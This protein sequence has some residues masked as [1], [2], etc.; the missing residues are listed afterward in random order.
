MIKPQWLE[1]P[2]SRIKF[3]GTKDVRAI[4]V[5]LYTGMLS[6]FI[7]SPRSRWILMSTHNVQFNDKTK[8]KNILVLAEEYLRY[9]KTSSN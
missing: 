6:V 2:M 8:K 3:N 7:R 5:L 1:L 9:L 4:E